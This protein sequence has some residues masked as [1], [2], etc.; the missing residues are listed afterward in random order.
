MGTGYDIYKRM[1]NQR[2]AW[3]GNE[4]TRADAV[5]R[6]QTL[7]D[8]D[9]DTATYLAVGMISAEEITLQPQAR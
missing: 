6:L 8:A 2:V 7:T 1:Q 5:R 4:P 3:L 9:S